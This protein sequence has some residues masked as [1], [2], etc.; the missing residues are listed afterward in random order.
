[1]G[2]LTRKGIIEHW[3]C[4]CGFGEDFRH[5]TGAQ[6][7]LRK[8]HISIKELRRRV[9]IIRQRTAR[10]TDLMRGLFEIVTDAR[11]CCIERLRLLAHLW[12]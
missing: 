6:A 12:L 10:Q 2:E 11:A 9:Q 5:F 8:L 4:L 3:Q 7:S 1:M